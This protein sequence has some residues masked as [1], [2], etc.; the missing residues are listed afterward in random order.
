[1]QNVKKLINH[2]DIV[3]LTTEE[4]FRLKR[5]EDKFQKN[6]FEVAFCGHFSAGKSTMLNTFLGAEVLPTSPIPT[7]ANIITI[8]NGE[9][10]LQVHSIEEEKQWSGEIPWDRVREWGMNG[11]D[12][13]GMTITANLPF[14]GEN[15][16]ILDTPGVDSTDETHEKMTV[17]QLYTTDI[18][19][20]VMDYNHV[21]SETNLFFLK[22]LS[23]EN[24]LLYIVINQI[25]KHNEMEIPFADYKMSL[26]RV[27]QEWE[28]Q[29]TK[30]YFTTMKDKEHHLNEFSLFEKEVKGIL[31]NSNSLLDSAWGQLEKGF[32]RSV[33]QR[34]K[35]EEQDKKARIVEEMIDRGLSEEQLH[36]RHEIVQNLEKVRNYQGKYEKDFMEK[37]DSLF[38]NV[39]LFPYSTTDFTRQWIESIQPGFKVGLLF[40]KKKTQEEQTNRLNKAVTDL[41]DKVKTQLLFHL[42]DYFQQLDRSKLSN[43]DQFVEELDNL[44]YEVTPEQF[45]KYV[46]ADHA[47]RNYVYTFTKDMTDRIVK[48]IRK[49]ANYVLNVY[50]SGLKE[51]YYQKEKSLLNIQEE[52]SQIEEFSNKLYETGTYY[53]SLVEKMED[54]INKTPPNHLF[55]KEVLEASKLPFPDVVGESFQHISIPANSVI[56]KKT[57]TD[58]F[59]ISDTEY[60]DTKS[61]LWLHGL[62]EVLHSY[63]NKRY[64][65]DERNRILKR[66]KRFENKQ[67]MI[68]LFGAFSAGK[69]SFANALLGE[70]VLP[71]SPNP[72]TATVNIVQKG[73]EEYSHGTAVVTFKTR[74]SLNKEVKIISEHLGYSIDLESLITWNP[75]QKNFISNWQKTYVTYL[76]TIQGSIQARWEELGST[77]SISLTEM[78]SF[79][80]NEQKACLVEKVDIYYDCELTEKGVVLVD[81]P[82][83]NSIYGRH[84]NVAF[85]QMRKSDAIFYLTYYNHAFSKADQYF[86]Q[87]IGKVNESFQHD[88]LY[89]V[90]NAS[91]LAGSDGEL[92]G[93]RHHVR[94]Q[95]LKNGISNPR[96]FH[97]SSKQGLMEK[98]KKIGDQTDSTFSD[99]E[100]YFNN[101]TIVELKQL[102]LKIIK[103]EVQLFFE[104]LKE[105]IDYLREEED[106]QSKRFSQL[107]ETV[108]EQKTHI[109]EFNFTNVNRQVLEE[110][111][112]LT[113]YLKERMKFVMNDYFTSSINVAVITESRKKELHQQLDAAIKEWLSQSQ[114]FLIQEM[115][116]TTIRIEEK[117]KELS[118]NWLSDSLQEIRENIPHLSCELEWEWGTIDVEFS[119]HVL[120]LD[121]TKYY[122][123]LKNKKDFFENGRVKELKEVLVADGVDI[124]G[125]LIKKM[126]HD[127]HGELNIKLSEVEK[128]IKKNL[129]NACDNE[130]KRFEELADKTIIETIEREVKQLSEFI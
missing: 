42:R 12:I 70:V 48:A 1:M 90:I 10:G 33:Q 9:L 97:L 45:E 67:Y 61:D 59:N 105:S 36:K 86:L 56:H 124:S 14:L 129:Y 103:S 123:Y 65:S 27:F 32:Y 72:T 71:V 20:Y 110:L 43:K 92:N 130:L 18:I 47:S 78:E 120:F 13:Q 116:S 119:E 4:K 63:K 6:I 44:T 96:L 88:K 87:Q 68:S 104:K 113:L 16:R 127:L 29:F 80:A 64:L 62:K 28:I 15:S 95:L 85:Q 109:Q 115:D 24:K 54:K 81:T 108:Q 117:M 19:V 102:S 84:T 46:S 111:D 77:L 122:S 39:T 79:V 126:S 8:Q 125:S 51:Y 100:S 30:L 89:F 66:L 49:Q 82:G 2:N 31:F 26:E 57:E 50:I 60:I 37:T 25:D 22:Q 38:K 121:P 69:S 128:G 52:L 11:N 99:F 93:V 91:D 58:Q 17:E 53:N 114:T 107:K 34:I 76:L 55:I 23:V 3:S 5:L 106:S 7:S 75:K 21:Q 98:Q 35:E 101:Q 112:Q 83:V 74:E 73:N 94:E 41:Q 118:R 40:S